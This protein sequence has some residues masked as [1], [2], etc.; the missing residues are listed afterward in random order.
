MTIVRNR[1]AEILVKALN[2][3]FAAEVGRTEEFRRGYVVNL[4][5]KAKVIWASKMNELEF[6]DFKFLT[7]ITVLDFAGGDKLSREMV[8]TSRALMMDAAGHLYVQ[9]E[10]DDLETTEEY[11]DI[12]EN[13]KDNRNRGG[14]RGGYGGEYGG[15]FGG[16][17]GGG[18]GG[19]F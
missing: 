9:N 14:G 8:S 17:Y 4:F 15:E 16:E 7:G 6:P 11:T 3:E 5:D 1:R 19:E 12:I 18:Y 2:S 10:M 13:A